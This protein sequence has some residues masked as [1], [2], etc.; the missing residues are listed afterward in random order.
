MDNYLSKFE[1]TRVLGV[2]A[3]QIANGAPPTVEIPP[4]MIDPVAIARLEMRAYSIPI[5]ITRTFPNGTEK[6]L[7]VSEMEYN[8]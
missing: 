1:L 6:V 3:T 4:G 7:K 2:R 8:I 5:T